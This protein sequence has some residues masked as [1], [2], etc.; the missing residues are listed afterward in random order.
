MPLFLDVPH[1]AK[2]SSESFQEA[3]QDIA[4]QRRFI[5]K[6]PMVPLLKGTQ[7]R[8][9][10]VGLPVHLSLSLSL[11]L[12]VRQEIRTTKSRLK[13]AGQRYENAAPGSAWLRGQP[14]NVCLPF[15]G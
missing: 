15:H 1:A 6:L 13:S 9:F 3:K 5:A 12:S 11:S 4:K 2:P 8:E 7:S 14:A 10:F